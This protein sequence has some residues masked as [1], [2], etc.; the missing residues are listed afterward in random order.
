[1]ATT[2]PHTTQALRTAQELCD[3]IAE[4]EADNEITDQEWANVRRLAHQTRIH[5]RRADVG[6]R[7]AVQFFRVTDSDTILESARAYVRELDGPRVA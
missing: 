6:M 4:A 7:S 2:F 3:A 5:S 1:M